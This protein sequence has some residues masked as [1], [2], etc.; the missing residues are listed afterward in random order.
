MKIK[1]IAAGG[2]LAVFAASVACAPKAPSLEGKEYKGYREVAIPLPG[3]RLAF[4]KKGDHVDVLVTFEAIMKDNRKE[5]VTATIIQNARVED[6]LK[7]AKLEDNGV[8]ELLLN[9]TE[10]DYAVLSKAQGE[11]DIIIRSQGDVEMVLMEMASFRKL[12][13]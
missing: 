12:F 3:N 1:C 2:L 6:V 7:P 5:K 4:V 13:R 9:P 11:I 8:V 10:A